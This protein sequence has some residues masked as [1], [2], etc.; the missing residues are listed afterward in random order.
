MK[1][2]FLHVSAGYTAPVLED[3]S[4]TADGG[5]TVLLGRNGVG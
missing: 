1:L 3:V 5:I 4:L 2:E